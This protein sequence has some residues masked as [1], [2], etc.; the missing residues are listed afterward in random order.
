M[1]CFPPVFVVVHFLEM[2]IYQQLV[3]M[4]SKC[5]ITPLRNPFITEPPATGG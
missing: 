5:D 4:R 2:Y 1:S 3:H